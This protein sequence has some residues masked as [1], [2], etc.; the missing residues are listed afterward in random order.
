M[1]AG[2]RACASGDGAGNRQPIRPIHCCS[3]PSLP[4]FQKHVP[5]QGEYHLAIA[6][7]LPTRGQWQRVLQHTPPAQFLCVCCVARPR[8]RKRGPG[9]VLPSPFVQRLHLSLCCRQMGEGCNDNAMYSPNQSVMHRS[10]DAVA[11]PFR[12]FDGRK[13]FLRK[14]PSS[15]TG[16]CCWRVDEG[17]AR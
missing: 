17:E 6:V 16:T 3:F 10:A 11:V 9:T 12:L 1:P 14:E 5:K 2:V 13:D 7:E 8:R 4:K 15:A